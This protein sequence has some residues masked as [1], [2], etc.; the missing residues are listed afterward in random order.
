MAQRED[1]GTGARWL[2]PID[3]RLIV[4]EMRWCRAR[5]A[6]CL[7]MA[8]GENKNRATAIGGRENSG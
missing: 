4:P 5:L 8:Q 1:A 7:I 3:Q 2:R 6:G